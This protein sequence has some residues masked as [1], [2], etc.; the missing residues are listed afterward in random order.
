MTSAEPGYHPGDVPQLTD[1]VHVELRG[2]QAT[3]AVR[4]ATGP[5]GPRLVELTIVGSDTTPVD[6]DALTRIPL[7]RLAIAAAQWL[8]GAGG[9][10]VGP[11]QASDADLFTRPEL[12]KRR[13]QRLTDEHLQTVA[14]TVRRAVANGRPVRTWSAAQLH[15]TPGTLDRWVRAAKN[16]GF[17]GEDEVPRKRRDR[18]TPQE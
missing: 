9:Q 14:D 11:G 5:Q 12:A 10:F 13:H 4:V 7:Q 1:R 8:D 15:T 16:R 3:Y 17:L 18:A 2:H 6:N